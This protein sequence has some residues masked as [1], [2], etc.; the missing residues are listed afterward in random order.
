MSTQFVI[1]LKKRDGDHHSLYY[2]RAEGDAYQEVAFDQATRFET[3]D[4]TTS[5]LGRLALVGN[6]CYVHGLN[7]QAD[8]EIWLDETILTNLPK[9]SAELLH[10]LG[11]KSYIIALIESFPCLRGKAEYFDATNWD[12]DRWVEA[13][14][15]W[16]HGERCAA[17]FIALVWNYGDANAKKWKFDAIDAVSVWDRNNLEAFIA[18]AKKPVLP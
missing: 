4:E 18:W 8:G 11:A 17:M 7:I 3:P 12:V 15:P 5:I 16:S 14:G 10:V 6:F 2:R 9:P 1:R 13:C